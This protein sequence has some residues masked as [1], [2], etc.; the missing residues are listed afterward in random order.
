MLAVDVGCRTSEN[1]VDG[2]TARAAARTLY[3]AINGMGVA[4]VRSD[5]V[6]QAK[7]Q[8]AKLAVGLSQQGN[9]V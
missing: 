1:L 3:F 2:N 5:V 8:F 4:L 9:E 6:L 7:Q